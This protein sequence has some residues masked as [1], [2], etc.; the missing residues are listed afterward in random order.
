MQHGFQKSKFIANYRTPYW[1]T[2]V[3]M[4]LLIIIWRWNGIAYQG[5]V[6]TFEGDLKLQCYYRFK[7]KKM[8]GIQMLVNYGR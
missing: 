8:V 3:D 5:Y 4:P 7:C 1:R 2:V 6:P